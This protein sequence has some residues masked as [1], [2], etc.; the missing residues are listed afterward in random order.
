MTHNKLLGAALIVGGIAILINGFLGR[1]IKND[2]GMPFTKQEREN[3]EAPTR[4]AR[5]TYIGF[6]LLLCG[7]GVYQY[8]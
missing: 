4:I 3:P 1:S 7:Y 2:V 8:L 5:S 6:G